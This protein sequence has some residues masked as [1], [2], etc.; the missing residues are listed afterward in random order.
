MTSAHFETGSDSAH[1]GWHHW[2]M[3][4]ERRFN[5][6]AIGPMIMRK[7]ADGKARLRMFPT[8]AHSNLTDNVHGG[9]LLG[10]MDI[11]L[12]AAARLF[13]I[14]DVGRAVTIDLSAQF[15]GAARIDEPLDAVVEL[16]RETGRM[17]FLRGLVVQGDDVAAAFSGA[18]RKPSPK[19]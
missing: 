6:Q 19:K 17:V 2:N 1:P 8:I 15:I 10:L 18:V 13:G 5:A 12:F 16:L 3:R 7:D 11:S 9:A 14:M 4:D